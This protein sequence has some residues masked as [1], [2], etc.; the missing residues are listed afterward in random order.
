MNSGLGGKLWLRNQALALEL[1]T[2]DEIVAPTRWQA[3]QLPSLLKGRCHVIHDGVDLNRF[4]PAAE[5]PPKDHLL[6]TYG[7]RGM[8]PMRG[9]PQFIES[10]LILLPKHQNIR[11]QIAGQDEICY[12]GMP[13]KSHATW[14]IWAKA[15]LTERGLAERV[16]WL[17][18]SKSTL[19]RLAAGQQ[20]PCASDPSIRRQLEPLEALA[21]Q[22][23][24]V[25]GNVAPAREL[26]EGTQSNV[27]YVDH[28]RDDALP[29]AIG[30]LL[31]PTKAPPG[32]ALQGLRLTPRRQLEK[33]SHVA[34]LQLTT[35]H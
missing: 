23:P 25:V 21:C 14:G 1:V 33:W 2:A 32:K 19:T 26:C 12:G 30:A 35:N 22:C 18:Y 7:T 34:G 9:F 31:K 10:L 11:V 6:L 13:P 28:R 17:G 24:M 20:L 27:T 15:Q 3:Q 29:R 8:E 16:E 4:K 5:K